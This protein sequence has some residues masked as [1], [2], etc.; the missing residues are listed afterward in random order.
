MPP[1]Y[2]RPKSLAAATV[3]AV[4]AAEFAVFL[5]LLPHAATRVAVTVAVA[6]SPKVRRC[7]LIYPPGWWRPCRR[8]VGPAR[9]TGG[10]VPRPTVSNR[11]R[12]LVDPNVT[13]EHRSR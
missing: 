8:S 5:V 10:R 7:R 3:V 12:Q 6:S 13:I 11:K 2:F 1:V 9:R 4:E